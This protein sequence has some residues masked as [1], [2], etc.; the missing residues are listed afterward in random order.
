[1]RGTV[2]TLPPVARQVGQRGTH[3]GSGAEQVDQ[4]HPVPVVAVDVD[5]R[6]ARVGAGGG[7]DGVEAARAVDERA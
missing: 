1:M 3:D 7:D 6:A 5:E 2:T 4:H